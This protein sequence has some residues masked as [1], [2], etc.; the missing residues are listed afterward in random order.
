MRMRTIKLFLYFFFILTAM[1]ACRKDYPDDIPKWLK[2]KISSC[3]ENSCCIFYGGELVI[4]EM[5]NRNDGTIIYKFD[6]QMDPT[7]CSYYDYNG[8][9]ICSGDWMSNCY[10]TMS[11]DYI[12][13]RVIWQEYPDKCK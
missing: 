6:D 9:E 12:L 1:S 3:K 5:K 13:S 4:N 8:S 11:N 7:G 10:Q 2:N